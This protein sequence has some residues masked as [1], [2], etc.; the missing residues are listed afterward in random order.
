MCR[1]HA[2]LA[3]PREPAARLDRRRA[4]GSRD[5]LQ[6]LTGEVAPEVSRPPPLPTKLAVGRKE[7]VM[8][9]VGVW[10]RYL[11]QVKV[12]SLIVAILVVG[13]GVLGVW[14][15]RT[16]AA[17]VWS[18]TR[19][20]H[21]VSPTPS[22]RALRAACWLEAARY[23]PR[24]EPG[25][26]TLKDVEQITIFRTNGVEAF[27]DLAT[28]EQ[29]Q[30]EAS[31]DPDVVAKIRSMQAAPHGACTTRSSSRP[32]TTG[33]RKNSSKRSTTCRCLRCCAPPQ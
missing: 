21:A 7:S 18:S 26:H 24:A 32:S 3:L 9:I 10:R 17:A 19:K 20:P 5:V 22:C 15:I 30:Q 29:V 28:L 14:N 4:R 16:Q 11:P 6:A 33:R 31:L 25:L 8:S 2:S 13:F 27:T 12:L 23:R 1:G